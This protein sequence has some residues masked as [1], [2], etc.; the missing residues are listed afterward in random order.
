MH[1]ASVLAAA[2][3]ALQPD[4]TVGL[5]SVR[6]TVHRVIRVVCLTVFSCVDRATAY[7]RSSLRLLESFVF[8]KLIMAQY[9]EFKDEGIWQHFLRE[10]LG[11]SAK[12]KLCKTVLKTVGGSTKGLHKHLKRVHDMSVLKRKT[13]DVTAETAESSSSQTSQSSDAATAAAV[14]SSRMA[15]PMNKYMRRENTLQSTIARMTARDGLPF[16]IFVTMC[17]AGRDAI[18]VMS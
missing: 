4:C 5:L 15:G 14:Q 16:R 8:T 12:C 18:T 13:A 6:T 10:K 11:Q 2:A 7:C 3:T 17:C 9:T 1:A